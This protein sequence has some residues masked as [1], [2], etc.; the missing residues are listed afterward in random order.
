MFLVGIFLID[1]DLSAI[2]WT[3]LAVSAA[4]GIAAYEVPQIQTRRA[5]RRNPSIQGEIVLLISD[6]GIEAT[7]ATGKS[8]LRWQAFVKCKETAQL[9]VLS[10]SPQRATYI[11]KRVLSSQQ[12]EEL[13]A[14]LRERIP[15][16][17]MARVT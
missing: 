10:T 3:W 8:E 6:M 12:I 14:L 1:H 7:F 2:G 16:E 4:I 17:T 5:M 11:P 13:R 15:P 9:F